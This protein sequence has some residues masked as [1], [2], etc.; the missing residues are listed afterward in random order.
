MN[1]Q[2]HT[3]DIATVDFEIDG[4][5]ITALKGSMIIQAADTAGIPIPRFCY[6]KKLPIA[7]VC[8]Q[9]MV[10]VEMGGKRVPKPQVACATPVAQGMK[11][12]TK[13]KLAISAQQNA[14]EFVLINH[15]LECP[16]CDQGGECELQDVSMG[17]GRSLSRLNI[18]KRTV[19]DEDIGPLVATYMTRCIHCTRC[20]RFLGDV[21]GTYEFGDFNRADFHVIGTY[22]GGGVASELSGNIIDVCPVGALTDKVYEFRARPWE[23]LARPVIGY[24]D[25]LGS[26]IWLHCMRDKVLRAVPRDNEAVNECWLADRD[27]Y[28][29]PGLYAIDR[30][31]RP[32]LRR[33]GELVEVEWGEAIA[34]V[35][36]GL[37]DPGS[38]VA[39]LMAPMTSCEEGYLLASLVRGLGSNRFDHRLRV[40]DFADGGPQGEVFGKPVEQLAHLGAALIIGS[41]PRH[42]LPLVN[43]RLR[44]ASRF[45][46]GEALVSNLAAYDIA[47]RH[48]ARV[49]AI[50]P[51]GFEFNF[52]LAGHSVV[53]PQDLI[54]RVLQFARAAGV[55]GD[56]ADTALAEALRAAA[57][58]PEFAAWAAA[59]KDAPSSVVILGEVAVQHPRASWLRALARLIAQA[60]DSAYDEFPSGANAVGL[61][62]IGAQS[63]DPAGNAASILAEPPKAL[64]TWQA[65]PED[66]A[67]PA[68]FVR[69][70]E[71]VGFHLH[72][73]GFV[74]DSV[75]RTADA[76]LPIG[77]PPEIDGTYVNVDGHVQGSTAA[78]PPPVEARPGWKVLRALGHQLGIAGFDF[79][80]LASVRAGIDGPLHVP[81][82]A[83]RTTGLVPRAPG[84]RGELRRATTVGI[85]RT[86]AVVRRARALQSHVLN[87]APALR[88]CIEDTRRLKLA[89]GQ[90]VFVDGVQLPVAIDRAVPAGC[91][92]IEAGDPAVRSLPPFGSALSIRAVDD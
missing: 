59:L 45:N 82:P 14:L 21:A 90:L 57:N 27:R 8:R 19:A 73:G 78:A 30:A 6:H 87:R 70:C 69:A 84:P 46:T 13:S 26:N 18:P 41:N 2:P 48:G 36:A 9:C 49:F 68:G 7:A 56:G 44:D 54:D 12:Y 71:R 16:I 11:V 74:N 33:A 4:H 50:N 63:S 81:A 88:L 58:A 23:M 52:E 67:D 91:A 79:I 32:M 85:Y 29:H 86:D 35:A 10:E 31:T 76:I 80:D 92:W 15:P 1:A 28:S 62:Q 61:A 34:F 24:H 89:K 37:R 66:C 47:T 17:Y 53:A 3:R 25:A 75:L 55:P 51:L 39:A 20:V 65:E 83:H 72:A 5:P 22:I 43:H 60:T 64:I 77:L 38:D 40:L 42:E